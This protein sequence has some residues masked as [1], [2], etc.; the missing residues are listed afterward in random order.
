[1][2]S[3]WLN[4]IP[5]IVQLV[6]DQKPRSV[7]DVGCGNGKYGLLLREYI[8]Y[9]VWTEGVEAFADNYRKPHMATLYNDLHLGDFLDYDKYHIERSKFDVVLMVDVL[10]HFTKKNGWKALE[11]ALTMAPKV[12]ISTPKDFMEQ[13]AVHGNPYERHLS[14]WK[15]Q[16]IQKKYKFLTIPDDKALI[17]V[18]TRK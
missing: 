17:G 4:Q 6:K 13:G 2:A 12:I 10:E 14:H 18:I 9:L 5:K 15:K 11:K 8:P 16:E 1:M 3:S 7:L